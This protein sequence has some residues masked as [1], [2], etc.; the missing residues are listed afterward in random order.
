MG[1]CNS[2]NCTDKNEVQTFEVQV[3]TSQLS[4]NNRGGSQI[5]Q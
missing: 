2:C 1:N 5:G 3:D 4:N